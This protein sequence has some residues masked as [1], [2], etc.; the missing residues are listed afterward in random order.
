M[1]IMNAYITGNNKVGSE[2][3]VIIVPTNIS[4]E[5]QYKW[6]RSLVYDGDYEEIIGFNEPTYIIGLNDRYLSCQVTLGDE[7]VITNIFCVDQL[8]NQE[9]TSNLL[10]DTQIN[11]GNGLNFNS[12]VSKISGASSIVSNVARINQSIQLILG[13]A[14]G[15]VPMMPSFGSYLHQY[16]FELTTDD[17]LSMLE[18]EVKSC[19][20]EQ[21]PRITVLEVTATYDDTTTNLSKDLSDHTVYIT[22]EYSI[23]GTNVMSSYIYQIDPDDSSERGGEIYE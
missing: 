17:T 1:P 11:V 3:S 4:N 19:L 2:L 14:H 21:E 10:N 22:I 8:S 23:V 6:Y 16:I 9:N 20:G 12:I 7:S 15:E 18:E 13:T 5:Y